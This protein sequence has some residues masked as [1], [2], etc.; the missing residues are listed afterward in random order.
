[1]VIDCICLVERV[2][3]IFFYNIGESLKFIILFR[4]WCVCWVFIRF[5]LMLCGFLMV[6]SIV[7]LVILWNIMC[8]V[9]LGFSFKILNKCYEIVFFLW[10]LLDVSYIILVFFVFVFNLV[11]NFFLFVGIL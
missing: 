7:V 5:I 10:F 9:F 6:F 3:F 4:I 8:L 2:G 11:I 1:M